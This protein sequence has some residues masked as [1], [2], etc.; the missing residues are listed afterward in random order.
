MA[1]R[2]WLGNVPRNEASREIARLC[3]GWIGRRVVEGEPQASDAEGV[4]S[5]KAADMVGLYHIGAE[6]PVTVEV[7]TGDWAS[8]RLAEA[9]SGRFTVPGDET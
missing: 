9:R 5:P 6:D 3:A 1:T 8:R 2:K 4:A 7:V